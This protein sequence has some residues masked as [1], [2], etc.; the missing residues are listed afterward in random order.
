MCPDNSK[1][2][3]E[4]INCYSYIT[5]PTYI[6]TAVIT[7]CKFTELPTAVIPALKTKDEKEVKRKHGWYNQFQSPKNKRWC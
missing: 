4:T 7:E 6:P 1:S 3:T 2:G 5:Y